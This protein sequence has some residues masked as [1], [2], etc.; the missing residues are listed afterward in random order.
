MTPTE[1]GVTSTIRVLNL[2]DKVVNVEHSMVDDQLS[3]A[4]VVQRLGQHLQ[5]SWLRQINVLVCCCG[6][7]F[8]YFLYVDYGSR[9]CNATCCSCV[10]DCGSTV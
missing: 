8:C 3:M 2:D 9:L 7:E 5:L 4:V 10:M 6:K 1:V